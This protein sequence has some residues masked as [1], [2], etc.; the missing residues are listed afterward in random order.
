MQ[1]NHVTKIA[2]SCI[3]VNCGNVRCRPVEICSPATWCAAHQYSRRR[4]ACAT[5]SHIVWWRGLR[6]HLRSRLW[7][8]QSF[9]W[10]FALCIYDVPSG[11]HAP[12]CDVY[13]YFVQYHMVIFGLGCMGLHAPR[14]E[15]GQQVLCRMSRRWNST[16]WTCLCLHRRAVQSVFVLLGQHQMF[17]RSSRYFG[18]DL[19]VWE[20]LHRFRASW[21]IST[22]TVWFECFSGD[23][24]WNQWFSQESHSESSFWQIPV[25][26]NFSPVNQGEIW[27]EHRILS[28]FWWRM[29]SGRGEKKPEWEQ[30]F[31]WCTVVF[32]QICPNH[33]EQ[34]CGRKPWVGSQLLEKNSF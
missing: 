29:R 2:L 17:L 16:L 26:S 27:W 10:Q 15:F 13:I 8:K 30:Q 20:R 6:P 5:K 18:L 14:R 3:Y 1:W 19:K 9:S 11:L 32:K 7:M 22:Q 34:I 25:G 33:V 31:L 28:T 4:S 12:R 21:R 23:R 24:L